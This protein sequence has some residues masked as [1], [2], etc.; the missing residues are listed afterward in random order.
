MKQY[1]KARGFT[2]IELLVVIGIIAVLAAIVIIAI[3]PARQFAQARDSQRQGNVQ[4]V[5]DAIGQNLADNKGLFKCSTVSPVDTIPSATTTINVSGGGAGD[6]S[7][8]AP[9]YLSTL[10]T[11]PSGPTSPSTGYSYYQDGNGR[12]HVIATTPEPSIPRTANIEVTR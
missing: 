3:N 2:L 11:D 9:K 10:P 7:C 12:I 8:L 5:L 1:K 6:L 4:T